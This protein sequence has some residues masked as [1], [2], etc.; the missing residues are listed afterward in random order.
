MSDHLTP[1]EFAKCFVNGA[2]GPEL[3]HIKDCP[4]CS[5]ELDRFGSAVASFRSA[6]RGRIDVHVGSDVTEV[7]AFPACAPAIWAPRFRWV[8]AA[9]VVVVLGLIP[10]LTIRTQPE[11][12]I[13]RTSAETDSDALMGAINLHLLRTV[14]AP[15]EPMLSLVP[16]TEAN[17][18]LG[19]V[20]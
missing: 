1:D 17:T 15:M 4:R 2:E 7:A 20:R 18:E 13:D 11:N 6:V 14:P 5:D 10:V 9:A 12:P 8:L 3:Q 19:G 16:S